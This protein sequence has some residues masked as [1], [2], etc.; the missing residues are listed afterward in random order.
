MFDLFLTCSFA[1]A[2]KARQHCKSVR[3]PDN[4][5]GEEGFFLGGISSP[6]LLPCRWTC[7]SY[8]R[9]EEMSYVARSIRLDKWQLIFLV[10]KLPPT[11][12]ILP[13]AGSVLSCAIRGRFQLDAAMPSYQ[14]EYF[15][16][17]VS[18]DETFVDEIRRGL[19]AC[20]V[21]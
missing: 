17:E 16:R 8:P 15:A 19:V 10:G 2:N 14:R 13:K 21:M 6:Q 9:T 11:G 7:L 20:R 12:N 4:V 5:Y 1:N 3:G 18:W